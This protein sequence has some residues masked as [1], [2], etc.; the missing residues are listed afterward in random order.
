MSIGLVSVIIPTWNRAGI[1]HSTIESV[2][3][4]TYTN[5]EIIVVDD[6]SS[7]NTDEVIAAYVERDSRMRYVY[8]PNAGVG[9][10][11]NLGIAMSKGN[12]L[13][14][15][16]SDDIWEE[17]KLELQVACLKSQPELG[18]VWTEM[19]AVNENGVVVK[20]RYLRTM[21]QA[22]R[23]FK[24]SDLFTSSRLI[25][26][27][28]PRLAGDFGTLRFYSGDIFSQM[29][30][31]SLV[32][33]STVLL[34]RERLEKVGYFDERFRPIGEDYDFHL[35]TCGEGPVGF[36]DIPS[37]K[38]QIGMPD[39]L[40][41]RSNTVHLARNFLL[42]IEPVI[43]KQRSRIHLSEEMLRSTL[44]YGNVWLGTELLLSRQSHEARTH[45]FRGLSYEFKFS[46][47]GLCILSLLPYAAV[48]FVR[49]VVRPFVRSLYDIFFRSAT[50]SD[51]AKA[52]S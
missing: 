30:T 47:L 17:W 33:T 7:D 45:L 43:E 35:R 49:T 2:L 18:M 12:Y 11:R 3:R 28:L 19:T 13:A 51:G 44:A 32:H 6:G 23:W 10:A 20:E 24:N 16:D 41:S 15:L 4:Q 21:Y 9:M 5:W 8:Q 29:I 42:T 1:I 39:Q 14:F 40:T 25:A 26:D 48:S 37:I 52:H 36:I 27:V 46:T 38:Y 22:Y 50:K 31:G 34:T